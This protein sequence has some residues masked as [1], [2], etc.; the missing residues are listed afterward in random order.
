MVPHLCT[1]GPG[2]SRRCVIQCLAPPQILCKE[3]QLGCNQTGPTPA[4]RLRETSGRRWGHPASVSVVPPP[5]PPTGVSPVG[6]GPRIPEPLARPRAAR[7]SATHARPAWRL[8][9]CGRAAAATS[10]P[11]P[12]QLLS[13]LSHPAPETLPRRPAVRGGGGE[14]RD[15]WAWEGED[16]PRRGVFL[17]GHSRC[18]PA[19]DVGMSAASTHLPPCS[20]AQLPAPLP[21]LEILKCHLVSLGHSLAPSTPENNQDPANL[22]LPGCLKE[23]GLEQRLLNS[24]SSVRHP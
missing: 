21:C 10:R 9:G 2:S 14:V 5:P 4:L 20:V 7:V 23:C 1:Q 6:L 3:T 17:S 22:G 15:P 16:P 24:D 18:A 12:S 11:P 13:A 19:T 8:G